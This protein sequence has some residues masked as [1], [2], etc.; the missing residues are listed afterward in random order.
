MKSSRGSSTATSRDRNQSSSGPRPQAG[1]SVVLSRDFETY[2]NLTREILPSL[3][4]ERG[5]PVSADHC[6]QRI[7]LD[8]VCGGIWYDHI[9]KP[10]VRHMSPD[11]A[12]AALSLAEGIRDGS[13]N[14][15]LLNERSKAWRRLA[16][17]QSGDTSRPWQNAP[18]QGTLDL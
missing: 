11:Q 14:L 8:S 17:T 6:F 15:H 12:S 16:R 7:I 4:R 1:A 5:W 10:A 18:I 13:V 3:A 9:A 2:L